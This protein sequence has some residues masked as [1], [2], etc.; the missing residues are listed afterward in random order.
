VATEI[1]SG[2]LRKILVA[3]DR[4][5]CNNTHHRAATSLPPEHVGF[6]L[7]MSDCRR[8][9]AAIH[10]ALRRQTYVPTG[11]FSKAVLSTR[12][13]VFQCSRGFSH[14]LAPC[15]S[16][17]CRHQLI[18]VR[19]ASGEGVCTPLYCRFHHR[20]P[21]RGTRRMA[22]TQRRRRRRRQP[23]RPWPPLS[24]VPESSLS[25]QGSESGRQPQTE[26][27]QRQHSERKAHRHR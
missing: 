2:C 19:A 12:C 20:R 5:E 6:A 9:D 8:M 24:P 10:L 16:H 22:E 4:P 14:L 25:P 11:A 3:V 15:C 13:L 7:M 26:L 27:S 18:G 1:P 21:V 23:S 17:D